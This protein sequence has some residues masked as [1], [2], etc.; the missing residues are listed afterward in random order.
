MILL[1]FCTFDFLA[2]D[3]MK[4]WIWEDL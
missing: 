1:S 4:E 2:C 3:N